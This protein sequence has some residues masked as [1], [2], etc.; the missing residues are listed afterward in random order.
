MSGRRLRNLFVL[1]V[2][3]G[4][5]YW[6]YKDRPTL[7]G[8]VD[9]LTSPLMRSR[10]AV[11]TSEGNRVVGD[12]TAAA[13]QDQTELP[14]GSLREGLTVE[15]VRGL[16]GPPDRI[17]RETREGKELMSWSYERVGR[18]IVFRDGRVVSIVVK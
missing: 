5:G 12:Q 11:K 3:A 18:T 7:S 6:I 8:I 13:I 1:A 10:T 4:M 9:T 16:M 14:V 17:S 15:E 2:F